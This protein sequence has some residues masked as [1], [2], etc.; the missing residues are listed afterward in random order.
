[1]GVMNKVL[2]IFVIVGLANIVILLFIRSKSKSNQGEE[3]KLKSC[4]LVK[5]LNYDDEELI[6]MVDNNLEIEYGYACSDKN[7]FDNMKKSHRNIYTLLWFDTEMQNG[8]IGEYLFSLSNITMEYIKDA[9]EDVKAFNI[10]KE[11]KKLLSENNILE[12]I[13]SIDKRDVEEY[14]IFM[15]KFEFNEFNDLYKQSDL[16]GLVANYI[17]ENICEFTNLNE[18]EL[19]IMREIEDNISVDNK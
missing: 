3:V 16:R 7:V 2:L 9:F 15:S 11:Y 14:T 6:C 10:L 8:G 4:S 19:K 13:S 18:E 12:A 1:M 17:R 5:I